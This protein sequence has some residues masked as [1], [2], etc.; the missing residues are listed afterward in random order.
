ME[1]QELEFGTQ[2]HILVTVI[3][4]NVALVPLPR[5]NVVPQKQLISDI[6][7]AIIDS[8]N[9][10]NSQRKDVQHQIQGK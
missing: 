9:A 1:T 8:R 3:V 10:V 7:S 4:P 2:G 5:R 6:F